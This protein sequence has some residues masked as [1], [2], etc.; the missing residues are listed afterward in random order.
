[1]AEKLSRDQIGVIDADSLQGQTL[2]GGPNQIVQRDA[3]GNIDADTVS[4][5]Q[6]G[7]GANELVQRDALGNIPDLLFDVY[8]VGSIYISTTST[9]PGVTFGFGTWVQ[10]SQGRT[11]LGEGTGAGG[12]YAAGAEAGSKDAVVVAHN[13][14][15][16]TNTTGNHNHTFSTG[17]GESSGGSHAVRAFNPNS[18]QTTSNAGNHSHSL[19]I[20]ST[21][22]S[23]NDANMMPYLVVYI[24]ERTA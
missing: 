3:S 15:G 17:L 14:S 16:S 21:G 12:T 18:S 8:P 6:V 11:L 7:T 22:V 2:G 20:N 24:W 4:G 19:S 1:M 10:V 5:V 23:G 13:H 9:N